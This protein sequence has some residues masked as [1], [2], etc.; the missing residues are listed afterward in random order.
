MDRIASTNS[1]A[2]KRRLW[3]S[4][5]ATLTAEN[6]EQ[7][8]RQFFVSAGIDIS[9]LVSGD[10]DTMDYISDKLKISIS[11]LEE[12]QDY[13]C[14]LRSPSI[15]NPMRPHIVLLRIG[16][17]QPKDPTPSG[18]VTANISH[19]YHAARS[20]DAVLS[21]KEVLWCPF[22]GTSFPRGSR[23]KHVN[24][25]STMSSCL[26]C[27]RPV[28]T[29]DQMSL[30]K[31]HNRTGFCVKT[32][33]VVACGRYGCKLTSQNGQCHIIHKKYC[34]TY[35]CRLCQQPVIIRGK[36]K[37]DLQKRK[38][39]LRKKMRNTGGHLSDDEAQWPIEMTHDSCTEMYCRH[40]EEHYEIDNL[41]VKRFETHTCYLKPIK[42]APS[43]NPVCTLD[44]ETTVDE[45]TM[46]LRVNALCFISP[47]KDKVL[48]FR[49]FE[50]RVFTEI[51]PEK[52]YNSVPVG[53]PFPMTIEGENDWISRE[54]CQLKVLKK[55]KEDDDDEDDN[56]DEHA[57]EL[58]NDDQQT[59]FIPFIQNDTLFGMAHAITP[60][61]RLTLP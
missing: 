57:Q 21:A 13:K 41:D 18:R 52:L 50:G 40:C 39:W 38:N 55:G 46:Q 35:I 45:G 28:L 37:E 49:K 23:K 53:E 5:N 8:A 31:P 10:I 44:L 7:L 26:S 36:Y 34:T 14:V 32:A 58:L 54:L 19:H 42:C 60:P 2:E 9:G 6:P 43:W 29:A 1:Q 25:T 17:L 61:K 3:K 59:D 27:R 51:M 4:L 56:D 12:S 16:H 33:N 47:V 20:M 15:Y 11:V 22:C 24:C 30:L 48:Q